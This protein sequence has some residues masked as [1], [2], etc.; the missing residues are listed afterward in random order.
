MHWLKALSRGCGFK[1]MDDQDRVYGVLGMIQSRST[2]HFVE[3]RPDIKFGGF[4]IDY[5]K[6]TSQVYQDVV[7]YLI[8]TDRNLDILQMFEDRRDRANDL[9]SWVPDWL[10][11]I[12]RPWLATGPNRLFEIKNYDEAPEQDLAETDK[13]RL[14][15]NRTGT[16]LSK[17]EL[18]LKTLSEDAILYPSASNMDESYT[19]VYRSDAFIRSELQLDQLIYPGI[20]TS[21]CND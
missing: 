18:D 5:S 9:P 15:G 1:V 6:T 19:K 13:L 7:K 16:P 21:Q 4:P 17:L 14:F 3:G 12:E 10:R 11:N 8:N 20:R 2:R